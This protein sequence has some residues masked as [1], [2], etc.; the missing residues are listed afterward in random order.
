MMNNE[1]KKLSGN[2]K[3]IE[4]RNRMTDIKVLLNKTK[5]ENKEI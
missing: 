4:R 3:R 2:R 5:T 1:N